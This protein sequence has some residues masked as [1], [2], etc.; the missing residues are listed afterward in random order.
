MALL[1]VPDRTYDDKGWFSSLA[2]AEGWFDRL[3][4]ETPSAPPSGGHI[5]F[6]ESTETLW[7]AAT[8]NYF[9]TAPAT[10]TTG[11]VLWV[12]FA[13]A[14]TVG[15]FTTVPSGWT[16]E[17]PVLH[18]SGGNMITAYWHVVTSGEE[19]SPPATFDFVWSSSLAGNALLA[20]FRGVDN[21]TPID[22]SYSS[23]TNG[24][25]T[26]TV[27]SIT[28]VTAN[29]YVIGGA[30]L[31]S[32]TT[33]TVNAPASGWTEIENSSTQSAGRGAVLALKIGR[34]HV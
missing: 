16:A 19:A 12:Q 24:T 2:T 11:D 27:P 20:V 5:T 14:D 1:L 10:L 9:V 4:T 3:F 28:T 29:A 30:Q 31:Q 33:Q 32:A 26:K 15:S 17:V 8:A 6:I 22:V 18:A 23:V 34:A 7:T 21:T 13:N 25:T